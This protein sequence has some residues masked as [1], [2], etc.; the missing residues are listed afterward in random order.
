[1]NVWMR[2]NVFYTMSHAMCIFMTYIN[3]KKLKSVHACVHQCECEHARVCIASIIQ[4][5]MAGRE[6]CH[7]FVVYTQVAD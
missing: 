6:H 3:K 5:K 1:M 2:M 7:A 4:L